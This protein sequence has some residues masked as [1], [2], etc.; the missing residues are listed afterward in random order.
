M[1]S[2]SDPFTHLN[3][4]GE[5]QMVD[6][7]EKGETHRRAVAEARVFVGA[8]AFERI[9]QDNLKKGNALAAARIAGIQAA[10]DTSRIIP[11]CHGLNLTGVDVEF[12]MD[13]DGDAIHIR[14]SVT[15][16]G[17]TGVEM[18]ALTA[19]SVAALTIYDMCKAVSK[20]IEI[21]DI[22]LISK[23]GGTSDDYRR[24]RSQGDG[25]GSS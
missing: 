12:E 4:A 8:N 25:G 9:R 14:T 5:I 2:S 16:V 13:E 24:N 6:V 3:K 11:L 10:K 7:S 17:P 1:D 23:T 20:D 22:R 21:S 19:A 15:T 18:E